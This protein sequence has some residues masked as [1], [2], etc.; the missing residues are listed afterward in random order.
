[1]NKIHFTFIILAIVSAIAMAHRP[2]LE[3]F[4]DSCVKCIDDCMTPYEIHEDQF[5]ANMKRYMS[6]V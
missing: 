4:T 1:M 6:N 2:N 5:D 3:C